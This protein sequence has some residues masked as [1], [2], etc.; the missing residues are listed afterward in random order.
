MDWQ[1]IFVNFNRKMKAVSP[2]GHG[3]GRRKEKIFWSTKNAKS[4][5]ENQDRD[6]KASQFSGPLIASHKGHRNS[7]FLGL[8]LSWPPLFPDFPRASVATPLLRPSSVLSWSPLLS[9]SIPCLSW[10]LL[11][12][13]FLRA[14]RAPAVNPFPLIRS[15]QDISYDARISRSVRPSRL[16]QTDS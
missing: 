8:R 4:A 2:R 5:K 11:P 7:G 10:P 13:A 15:D 14:L 12:Q 1:R 9:G 3:G 6:R 16:D